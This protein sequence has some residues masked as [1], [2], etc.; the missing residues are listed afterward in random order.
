MSWAGPF[1]IEIGKT[2]YSTPPKYSLPTSPDLTEDTTPLVCFSHL[3]WNFVYQRPQHL[4]SRFARDFRVYFVEE[5]VNSESRTA[6]LDVRT[7]EGG[8]RVVVPKLPEG[9]TVEQTNNTL[10]TLLDEFFAAEGVFDPVLWY[11]TPMSLDFTDH[12]KGRVTVYDC[13]DELSA[14]KGAPPELIE[15]E[16]ALLAKADLVFTGGYS[17]WEAKRSL[18]AN[19]HPF[20][21]SVD[22]AHF[23]QARAGMEEPEDQ[24][25]IPHPRLGFYGVIDERLDIRLLDELAAKRPDLHLVMVGPVVKIDPATLPK[26]P[27]IHY[28]GPKVYDELPQYLAGWDVALMPFA[29]NESTRFI[30]P[31]KTPEYLAGGCPVVSTAIRDVVR[32]YGDSGVVRIAGTADEFAAAIDVALEDAKDRDRL[33]RTAD[34]VLSDMSW[35]KTWNEMK[36]KIECAL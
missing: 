26:H 36:E 32:T 5:P 28:L 22:V 14:F 29:L 17:L 35:D 15:R 9:R 25:D 30:S 3:R 8:V 7:E 27:N 21:S 16:R 1:Q 24:K 20:P 31:T 13:M 33:L 10:R 2:R 18:H 23:A 12:L 19:A 4:L 11:Y 34:A 6:W